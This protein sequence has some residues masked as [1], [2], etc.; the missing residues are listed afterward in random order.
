MEVCPSSAWQ[1]SLRFPE[2]R[3]KDEKNTRTP[4]T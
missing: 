2:L 1:G 3:K 4:E